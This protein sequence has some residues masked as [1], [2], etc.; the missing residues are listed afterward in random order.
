MLNDCQVKQNI[1]ISRLCIIYITFLH[2]DDSTCKVV[3]VAQ[4]V[5]AF[6]HNDNMATESRFD[7][8]N[9]RYKAAS[10]LQKQEQVY[11]KKI[12]IRK[13]R[14]A[15]LFQV[16]LSV[17]Q[18]NKVFLRNIRKNFCDKNTVAFVNVLP[19]FLNKLNQKC[20]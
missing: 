14:L 17:L 10:N 9:W 12:E 6:H 1:T 3:C 2:K 15:T 5:K 18:Y 13:L 16:V 4:L 8:F 20:G 7:V 11:A 19:L